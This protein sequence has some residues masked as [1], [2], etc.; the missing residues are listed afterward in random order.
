[1]K[2]MVDYPIRSDQNGDAPPGLHPL[3]LIGPVAA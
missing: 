2:F 3:L 1:M